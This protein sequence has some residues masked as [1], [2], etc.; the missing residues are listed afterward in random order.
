MSSLAL[1][2][3]QRNQVYAVLDEARPVL[4]NLHLEMGDNRR[5]LMQLSLAAEKYSQQLNE[6]AT[7]QAELKKNL[8]V[9]IGDVKSQAFALL[10]E[11]QQAS[12]LNRQEDFRQG[13]FWNRPEH[14]R[15]CW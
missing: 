8:I 12:F 10:D 2:K 13:P 5:A 11:Q 15:S 14:R 3:E 1:S 6:L 7:K 9:K 4:R